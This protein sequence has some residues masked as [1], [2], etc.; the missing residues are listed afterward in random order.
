MK[1]VL[2][3]GFLG[4]GKT[5]AII[6]ACLH[7]INDKKR[8]G[9]I[10]NDQGDQQVDTF[11]VKGFGIPVREVANGCFCCN[12]NQ[13]N[14]HLLSLQES[15]HPDFIFAESVGSCTD[16]VATIAKPLKKLRPDIETSISIFADAGLMLSLIEERSSFLEESVRY[17]YKKQLEEADVLI[18]NKIDLLTTEQVTNLDA[19]VK[20]QYPGKIILR[21]NS[22]NKQDVTTWLDTLRSVTHRTRTSLSI[23]YDIYGDG[24]ARLAWL[25]E[26]ITLRAKN[27]NAV[28]ITRI[29]IG[30]IFDHLQANQF[31]IG[32]LKFFLETI[33]A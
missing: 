24:E 13:L 18:L 8:V 16:L 15:D 27:G 23:D 5:T 20:S 19:V 9:V 1:I 33:F 10:T 22:L 21:Q 3:G 6:T 2:A 29:I 4:S 11:F 26:N 17:I 30:A 12:Y 32:H 7:L 28:F 25:D 31:T 14:E